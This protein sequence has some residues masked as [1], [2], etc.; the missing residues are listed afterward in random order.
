MAEWLSG[1]VSLQ[2]GTH[3]HVQTNDDRIL[4]SWTW[5]MTDVGMTGA[6]NSSIG[7]EF[8]GWLPNFISG[9]WHF[10]PKRE[11]EMGQW[12]VCGLVVEIESGKCVRLEKIRFLEASS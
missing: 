9:T 1:R 2:Y 6:L 10:S 5:A 7:Q 8:A 4:A 3:T 11:T 12:V